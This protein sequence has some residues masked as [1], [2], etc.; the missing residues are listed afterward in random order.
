MERMF[1]TK[2]NYFIKIILFTCV[3]SILC[4]TLHSDLIRSKMF[5]GYDIESLNREVDTFVIGKEIIDIKFSSNSEKTLGINHSNYC[6][7]IIYTQKE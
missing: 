3:F 1:M 7:I 6:V 5:S 4:I 2:T